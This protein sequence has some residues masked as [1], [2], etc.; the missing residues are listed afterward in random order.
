MSTHQGTLRLSGIAKPEKTWLEKQIETEEEDHPWIN[1]LQGNLHFQEITVVEC[2]DT[3]KLNNSRK[4][5]RLK[6]T[7]YDQE[8]FRSLIDIFPN[9]S[10]L[11]LL[12]LR[13]T[14]YKLM[15]TIF[16]CRTIAENFALRHFRVKFIRE[17]P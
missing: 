8:G 14:D 2:P 13:I 11:E 3:T 17:Q 4:N 9:K 1:R 15:N 12:E 6:A 16:S 5:F 7:L 10:I